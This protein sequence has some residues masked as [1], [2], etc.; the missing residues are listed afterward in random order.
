MIV[1]CP[2]WIQKRMFRNLEE[3]ARSK[4]NSGRARQAQAILDAIKKKPTKG[5]SKVT[6]G[7]VKVKAVVSYRNRSKQ[8]LRVPIAKQQKYAKPNISV[9]TGVMLAEPKW[10][11]PSRQNKAGRHE[12]VGK[13]GKKIKQIF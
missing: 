6:A 5:V 3:A 12:I 9:P 2:K 1:D 11:R 7:R 8:P 13:S 10:K 4:I